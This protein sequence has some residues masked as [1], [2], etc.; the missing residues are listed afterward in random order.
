[1][2]KSKKKFDLEKYSDF[3]VSMIIKLGGGT[4]EYE[5]E[6][7]IEQWEE[8]QNHLETITAKHVIKNGPKS[9]RDGVTVAKKVS[10]PVFRLLTEYFE[11]ETFNYTDGKEN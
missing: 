2:K 1:M 5:I 6:Y 3:E 11:Y 7:G 4:N 10:D 8:A 9:F